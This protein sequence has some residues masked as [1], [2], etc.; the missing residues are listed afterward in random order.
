ML[1][2]IILDYGREVVD[3]TPHPMTLVF[4]LMQVFVQYSHRL[5]RLDIRIISPA[6]LWMLTELGMDAPYLEELSLCTAL[7]PFDFVAISTLPGAGDGGEHGQSS[8]WQIPSLRKLRLRNISFPTVSNLTSLTAYRLLATYEDVKTLFTFS[9]HLAHLVLHNLMTVNDHLPE[10]F[11]TILAP[12]LRSIAISFSG[13]YI[14]NFLLVPNLAYLE[15]DGN[16]SA[17]SL[18]NKKLRI[19][20]GNRK[21]KIDQ[22]FYRSLSGIQ[23][24]ELIRMSI[25]DLFTHEEERQRRR[26]IELREPL[27]R[28]RP[29]FQELVFPRNKVPLVLASIGTI[30]PDLQSITVDVLSAEQL[31][32]LIQFVEM[33]NLKG[34]GRKIH[35]MR[36]GNDIALVPSQAFSNRIGSDENKGSKDVKECLGLLDD[37]APLGEMP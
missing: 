6:A 23:E 13:T 3:L 22:R 12:S 37:R 4:T 1:I 2:S 14:F 20:N 24:L 32:P 27:Y 18:F 25:Q 17:S 16:I 7:S 19:C 33:R 15:I 36:K 30:W 11:G 31:V 34:D 9:P 21:F 5:R 26:S 28:R 35:L 29:V 10:K 8:K